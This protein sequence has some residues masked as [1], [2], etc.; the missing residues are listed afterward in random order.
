MTCFKYTL[1]TK[2]LWKTLL[3]CCR[4]D[5][6]Q[7]RTWN[8]TI[9]CLQP[10]KKFCKYQTSVMQEM[11]KALLYLLS[12][13]N[14]HNTCLK[15]SLGCYLLALGKTCLEQSSLISG[16]KVQLCNRVKLSERSIITKSHAVESPYQNQQG[17][18]GWRIDS[19]W[20]LIKDPDIIYFNI[21]NTWNELTQLY[22]YYTSFIWKI[23]LQKDVTAAKSS[24]VSHLCSSLSFC[25][26]FCFA[27]GFLNLYPSWYGNTFT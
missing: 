15:I 2:H 17:W 16:P 8:A 23:G 3:C 21:G 7:T 24:W 12:F 18:A 11:Q 6:T 10:Q 19:K 13:I 1:A 4:S 26:F 25:C 9:A 22:L 27:G 20:K 5:V 14:P